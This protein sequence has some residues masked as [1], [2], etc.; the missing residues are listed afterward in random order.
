MCFLSNEVYAKMLLAAVGCLKTLMEPKLG[1]LA[2]LKAL[3]YHDGK[4]QH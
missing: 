2:E 3:S 4:G 1:V